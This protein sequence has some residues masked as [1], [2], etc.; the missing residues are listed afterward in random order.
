MTTCLQTACQYLYE[1]DTYIA[2]YRQRPIMPAAAELK[3]KQGCNVRILKYDGSVIEWWANGTVIETLINGDTLRFNKKPTMDDAVNYP[4]C[5][6][7]CK[8]SYQ[9][10]PNGAVTVLQG[11]YAFHWSK[12]IEAAREI[13]QIVYDHVKSDGKTLCWENE[14]DCDWD[15]D[16]YTYESSW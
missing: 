15:T 6:G 16:E 4:Y 12:E 10:H 11:D 7:C 9:F 14:C 13:G 3:F 2:T 8:L 5:R 1:T